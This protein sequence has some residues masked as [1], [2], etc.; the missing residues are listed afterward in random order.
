MNLK[1]SCALWLGFL[2]SRAH[3]G[4]GWVAAEA[5]E[6][7][8]RRAA[9]PRL[10]QRESGTEAVPEKGHRHHPPLLLL[11]PFPLLSQGLTDPL[12]L[13]LLPWVPC[14]RRTG[15]CGR[16]LQRYSQG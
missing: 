15:A 8:M 12:L 10:W 11:L 2:G 13:L 7:L 3:L 16:R 4:C 1:G 5:G 9:A 6:A 14:L